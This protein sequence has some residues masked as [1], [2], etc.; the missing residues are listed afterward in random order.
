MRIYYLI[1]SHIIPLSGEGVHLRDFFNN[2]TFATQPQGDERFQKKIRMKSSK[3]GFALIYQQATLPS[4]N[5]VK[6]QKHNIMVKSNYLHTQ[7]NQ[8][9]I[10]P[11]TIFKMELEEQLK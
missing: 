8:Q 6:S 2:N 3:S 9:T 11:M 1:I 10:K 5:I 7:I 4:H